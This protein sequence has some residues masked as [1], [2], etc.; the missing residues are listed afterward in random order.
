MLWINIKKGL[1]G[2]W[3]SGEK[4][5]DAHQHVDEKRDQAQQPRPI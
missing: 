5:F 4:D 3:N 2:L 1:I